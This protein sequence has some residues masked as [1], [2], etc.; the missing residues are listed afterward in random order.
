MYGF[1]SSAALA[2]VI[3]VLLLS[4]CATNP[5]GAQQVELQQDAM[6]RL[7]ACLS[8]NIDSNQTSATE[9]SRLIDHT[10][11]GHRRDVIALFPPHLERQVDQMLVSSAERFIIDL[12][13]PTIEQNH[14]AR[15]V[16]TLLR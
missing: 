1:N 5:P 12:Q 15:P 6:Q 13:T 16:K 7:K 2:A 4:A 3:S 9:I 10:C 8:R 11:E 14:N